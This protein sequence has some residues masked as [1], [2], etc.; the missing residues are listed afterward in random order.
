V[1]ILE[2]G[3]K[4]STYPQELTDWINA[5][6]ASLGSEEQKFFDACAAADTP[7]IIAMLEKNPSLAKATDKGRT[8]IWRQP[9]A[10]DAVE[11]EIPSRRYFPVETTETALQRLVD[12]SQKSP[13]RI[14]AIKVLV[15]AGVDLKQSTSESGS[16]C[17]RGL[18]SLPEKLTPEELDYLLSE[19]ADPSVGWCVGNTPPLNWLVRAFFYEQDP[20]KRP[21]FPGLLRVFIKHG[22]DPF[23]QMIAL[24][25]DFVNQQDAAK[26]AEQGKLLRAFIDC[27]VDSAATAGSPVHTFHWGGKLAEAGTVNSVAQVKDITQDP[28]LIAILAGQ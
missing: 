27:G 8:W 17:A 15:E 2:E 24:S 16:N 14:K 11:N 21:D 28:E 18:V 7:T 26:K 10:E 19:G 4:F 12:A 23:N 3:G 6:P 9:E 13:E 5:R 25:L 22:V 1:E 20:T